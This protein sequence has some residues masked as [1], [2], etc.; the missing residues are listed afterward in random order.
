MAD[1]SSVNAPGA[2]QATPAAGEPA[3]AAAAAVAP[4]T[5]EDK[6]ELLECARYGETEDLVALLDAGVEAN[7]CDA[8][9]NTALH[10]A[11]ANGHTGACC[12]KLLIAGLDVDFA[13]VF[14]CQLA[15]TR[16]R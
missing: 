10:K 1:V 8:G 9:G 11:C 15:S 13:G 14:F 12:W 6:L 3:A 5:E 7:F 16:I 4:I 2:P